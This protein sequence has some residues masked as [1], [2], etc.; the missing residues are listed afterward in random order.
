MRPFVVNGRL[1]EVVRVRPD[2]PRLVDREGTRRVATAD[3]LTRTI[4]VS[5]QVRPPLLD[6]VMVHEAAH[7]ITMSY[8]LLDALHDVTPPESWVPVEEWAAGLVESFGMEAAAAASEALG[9]PV[10]VRGFCHDRP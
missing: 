9:R 1:W 2:D 10:C 8:G 5:E 6:R 4:A 7:A 3:P